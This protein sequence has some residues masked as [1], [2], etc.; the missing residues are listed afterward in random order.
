MQHHLLIIAA[1]AFVGLSAIFGIS[2]APG[3]LLGAAATLSAV[4]IVTA[5]LTA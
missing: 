1:V 3:L 2:K 4:W 5:I